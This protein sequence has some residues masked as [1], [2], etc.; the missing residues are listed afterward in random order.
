MVSKVMGLLSV[1]NHNFSWLCQ[2]IDYPTGTSSTAHSEDSVT[3]VN[4]CTV[5][6]YVLIA[7]MCPTSHYDRCDGKGSLRSHSLVM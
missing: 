5:L 3:T 6:A 1:G 4:G 7:L 2:K